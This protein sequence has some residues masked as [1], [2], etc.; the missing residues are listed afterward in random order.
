MR[1]T[2]PSSSGGVSSPN[3]NIGSKALIALPLSALGIPENARTIGIALADKK[4]PRRSVVN[5]MEL[6]FA[7][8][9]DAGHEY[10]DYDGNLFPVIEGVL[11][12]L[13]NDPG[14][15]WMSEF[16]RR[17]QRGQLVKAPTEIVQLRLQLIDL[18]LR[19]PPIG[20]AV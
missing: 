4:W 8:F 9:L 3:P 12:N 7:Y 15:K 17:C 16:P 19:T 20:Y 13:F 6:R 14:Y 1:T 18:G 10:R 5:R 2:F 11:E